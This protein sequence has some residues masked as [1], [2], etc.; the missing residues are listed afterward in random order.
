MPWRKTGLA[1]DAIPKGSMREVNL[2][3]TSVLLV[4][5]SEAVRAVAAVCT[6]EGGILGDGQL[7]GSRLTCPEHQASFDVL[8]GTVLA[9]P[10][11]VEPPAG[12]IGPIASYPTRVVEGL[13]EVELVDG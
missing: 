11:G 2:D 12:A 5:L 7:S 3:G 4:R 8:T 1:L 9:D 10:D 6:H 13:V